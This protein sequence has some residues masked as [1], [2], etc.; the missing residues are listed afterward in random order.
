MK[1]AWFPERGPSGKSRLI[2]RAKE[3]PADTQ[4]FVPV[5]GDGSG[6]AA[7]VFHRLSS[8]TYEMPIS[9]VILI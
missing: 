5:S 4:A 1:R 3:P 9:V 7:P 2:G 6:G 8:N